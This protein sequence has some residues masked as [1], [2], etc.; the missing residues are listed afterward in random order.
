MT[1]NHTLLEIP[2]K[3]LHNKQLPFEPPPDV[4]D[5]PPELPGGE[6]EDP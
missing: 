1:I 5:P 2:G 4:V 3:G 6:V